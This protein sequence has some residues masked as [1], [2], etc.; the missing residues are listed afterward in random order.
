MNGIMTG[1]DREIA[2]VIANS[3]CV[4][5]DQISSEKSLR[6][7]FKA[8]SLDV[9]NLIMGIEEKFNVSIAN[10]DVSGLETVGDVYTFLDSKIAKIVKKDSSENVASILVPG[11][12][13]FKHSFVVT[14]DKTNAEGNVYFNAI[15]AMMGETRDIFALNIIPGLKDKIGKD[16]ILITAETHGY[17]RKNLYFSDAVDVSVYIT[18]ILPTSVI[19]HFDITKK[20]TDE[21]HSEGDHLIVFASPD[22]KPQPFPDGFRAILYEYAHF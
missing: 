8:D 1:I 19:L 6:K 16:F 12:K 17:Y 14:L 15:N 5:I 2:E 9:Q 3:L 11:G 20:D 7:D 4:D 13:T 21:L 18:K 10:E 22:G